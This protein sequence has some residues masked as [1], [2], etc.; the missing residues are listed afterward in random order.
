[1]KARALTLV[2]LLVA[3][4]PA[5]A[6]VT[7]SISG[8]VTTPRPRAPQSTAPQAPAPGGDSQSTN[9]F[10]GSVPQGPPTPEPL[11]LS[12]KDAV[13]RALRNNLGLLLQRRIG[14]RRGRR[15]LA[16]ARGAAART[17]RARCQRTAAGASTSR[18]SAF[19][20]SRSDRRSVQRLRRARVPVAAGARLQR[21]QRGARRGHNVEA[22]KYSIKSA[23][24]LVV[25]VA[26]NLY[27]EAVVGA[28]PRRRWR[29]RRRRPR[30]RCSSRRW[31]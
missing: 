3:A 24:D 20:R 27:L 9:P 28:Q 26:V 11:S 1:M 12:A 6:Q 23:R 29:A 8:P 30:R 31:I 2:I 14:V 4:A 5:G 10:F 15:P 16:R 25:L 22:A 19:P 17:S 13:D 21:A 18:R 7:G